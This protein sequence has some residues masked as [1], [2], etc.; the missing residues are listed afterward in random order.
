MVV[1]LAVVTLESVL[2][3]AAATPDNGAT[4]VCSSKRT[5]V[6]VMKVRMPLR[7]ADWNDDVIDMNLP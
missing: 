6:A 1:E 2:E 4:A 7:L 3:A 5:V